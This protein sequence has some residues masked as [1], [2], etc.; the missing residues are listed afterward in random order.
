MRELK[1]FAAQ[2]RQVGELGVNTYLE[3]YNLIDLT[4]GTVRSTMRQS[5]P[6]NASKNLLK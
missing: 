6:R 1:L 5:N 3:R 4:D 2:F